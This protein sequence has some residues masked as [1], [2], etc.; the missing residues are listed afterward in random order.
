MEPIV[1]NIDVDLSAISLREIASHY[2]RL[3]RMYRARAAEL[4][5]YAA[6]RRKAEKRLDSLANTPAVL[7]GYLDNGLSFEAALEAAEAA[8]VDMTGEQYAVYCDAVRVT[9]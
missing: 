2:E 8:T 4:D 9:A 1:I 3:A 6:T 7:D 5:G